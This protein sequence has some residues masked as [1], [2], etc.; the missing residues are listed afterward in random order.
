MPPKGS[1][2]QHRVDPDADAQREA[3]EDQTPKA[4]SPRAGTVTVACRLPG[5][6]I[7]QLYRMDDGQEQSPLGV[8]DVKI[9]RKVGESV[10][11]HG[12]SYPFG[13][14]PGHTIQAGYGL[15]PDVPEDFW[16]EWLKQ[17]RDS[18]LI[19]SR[20]VFA[21]SSADKVTAKAK[22]QSREK[23][24]A[25]HMAKGHIVGVPSGL[26]P[27]DRKNLPKV[28]LGMK[29]TTSDDQPTM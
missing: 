21:Y 12:S 20:V 15:T 3:V 26:E 9:A 24:A 29:V 28:G 10:K 6:V 27:L 5:G 22:E 16:N 23:V 1:T 4:T 2:S 13:I 25:P 14:I 7:L 18:D 19:A 11:L 17:N 8:R